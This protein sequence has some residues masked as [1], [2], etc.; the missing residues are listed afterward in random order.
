MTKPNLGQVHVLDENLY[1]LDDEDRV[2]HLN[3]VNDP[4][5]RCVAES[6]GKTYLAEVLVAFYRE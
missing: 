4:V 6:D 2:W 5:W 1:G 3:V